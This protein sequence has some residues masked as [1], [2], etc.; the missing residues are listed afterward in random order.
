MELKEILEYLSILEQGITNK[1]IIFKERK[2]VYGNIV[3][4]DSNKLNSVVKDFTFGYLLPDN[5]VF[6]FISKNVYDQVFRN[7][8]D[9]KKGDYFY[10]ICSNFKNSRLE[11]DY[12]TQE[13]VINSLIKEHKC[14]FLNALEKSKKAWICDENPEYNHSEYIK[15]NT[16]Y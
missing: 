8:I 14:K 3:Y 1:E 13:V 7:N 2:I 10:V 12:N 16:Y 9:K 11:L 15:K 6:D 4:L 5:Q